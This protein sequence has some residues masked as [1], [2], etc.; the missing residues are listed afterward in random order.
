MQKE[1]RI[2]LI[3][4]LPWCHARRFFKLAGEVRNI[5]EA[6]GD[7]NVADAHFALCEKLLGASNPAVDDVVD[8]RTSRVFFEEMGQIIGVQIHHGRKRIAIQLVGEVRFDICLHGGNSRV[9][10]LSLI[11]ICPTAHQ[12]QIPS[13]YR[14]A[15]KTVFRLHTSDIFLMDALSEIRADR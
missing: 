12:R 8:E 4:K 13:A 3:S 1:G 14:R 5:L 6:A 11:H 2:F 7:G 15:R 10:G 9:L